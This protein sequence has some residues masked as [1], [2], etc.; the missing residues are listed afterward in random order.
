MKKTE[1]KRVVSLE[2]ER[3]TVSSPVQKRKQKEKE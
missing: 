3:N 2:Y 1:I